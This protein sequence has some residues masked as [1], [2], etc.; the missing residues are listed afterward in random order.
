MP[1]RR[2]ALRAG[3]VVA[4]ALAGCLGSSPDATTTTDEPP[5]DTA[6]TT[7]STTERSTTSDA[8]DALRWTLD[9]D[10]ETERPPVLAADTVYAFGHA[11]HAVGTDGAAR[12]RFEADVPVQSRPLVHEGGVYVVTGSYR[13]SPAGEEFAA[14]ALDHDGSER[15]RHDADHGMVSV[16]A[17]TPNA[18]FVGTHDDFLQGNGESL[19][20]LD[21]TDGDRGWE[22][23]IG[24]ANGGVV[25]DDTV[26]AAYRLGVA[27]FDATDGTARWRAS[28]RSLAG[29]AGDAVVV[30]GQSTMKALAVADGA[31]R[32]AFTPSAEPST[33][34]VVG[35]TVYVNADDGALHAVDAGSGEE[36]WRA[37]VGG[38]GYRPPA[39]ADDSVYAAGDDLVA[40]DAATGDERWRYDAGDHARFAASAD[41]AYVTVGESLQALGPDGDERWRYDAGGRPTRPVVGAGGVYVGDRR[42]TLAA[43]RA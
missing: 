22:V 1:T 39:V 6:T 35:E 37:S 20:A 10:G 3:G 18:A 33:A 13:G 12:W 27:G 38:K 4:A 7:P 5:T 25:V 32:W 29:V 30:V 41:G 42:G 24:D 40:L 19:Y 14:H 9:T 17:A 31:E 16:L 43:L 23:G 36:R 11:L 15:W 2:Q 34:T 26:V 8:T 21:A 28:A